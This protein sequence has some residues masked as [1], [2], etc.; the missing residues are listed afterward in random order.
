MSVVSVHPSSA[1]KERAP[2]GMEV[3][4]LPANAQMSSAVFELAPMAVGHAIKHRTVSE[5]WY[6]LEGEGELWWCSAATQAVVTLEPGVSLSIPV[7]TCFQVRNVGDSPLRVHGVTSPPWPGD[8]EARLVAGTWPTE[9]RPRVDWRLRSAVRSDIPAL[10]EL[11]VRSKAWWGYDEAFLSACAE[12]LTVD[13]TQ[14]A[15]VVLAHHRDRIVGFYAVEPIANGRAELMAMY[16]EPQL[17]GTGVGRKL[18]DEAL[19]A[20]HLLECTVLE[21]QADPSARTFYER[22]GATH[23][24]ERAS[25]SIP[26]RMLPLLEHRLG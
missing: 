9:T 12:Q 22:M 25:G 23:V 24:S 13:E 4:V 26:G 11:A 17:I 8:D 21:I 15:S 5:V 16:V 10:S 18:Y 2:D 1:N 20:T 14:L 6:I 3:T 19:R 7:D